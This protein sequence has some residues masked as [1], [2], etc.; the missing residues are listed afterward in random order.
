MPN[1]ERLESEENPNPLRTEILRA[2]FETDGCMNYA[3]PRG[4]GL[5]IE[6]DWDRIAGL[7]VQV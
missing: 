5:G 4:P 6:P 1:R 3:V 2:P 7:T